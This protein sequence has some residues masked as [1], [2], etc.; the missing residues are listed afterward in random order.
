MWGR[1]PE[2]EGR[3]QPP[4]ATTE[5]IHMNST[6]RSSNIVSALTLVVVTSIATATPA[7]ASQPRGPEGADATSTAVY[8]EPLDALD[9]RT[10]AEY[11][12]DHRAGDRRLG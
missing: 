4:S 8:A 1:T 7:G 3:R 2:H 11:I 9:G 5:V 10:L 12:A 6:A